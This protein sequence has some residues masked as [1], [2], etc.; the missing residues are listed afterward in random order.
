MTDQNK[1][2]LSLLI[3]EKARELGFAGCGI[4]KAEML[5]EEEDHL[6]KWLSNGYQ[7]NLKYMENHVDKRL[8]PGKLF[9]HAASVISVIINYRPVELIPTEDNYKIARYAYGKD[10]HKVIKNKLKTLIREIESKAGRIQA[11]ILIDSAPILEKAWTRR[12]GLGWVGKNSIVIN[13]EIGSFFFPS[14]IV[15]DLELEYN[16]Q[17][18]ADRCGNC[19][20]CIDS[21]PTGAL[22]APGTLD[23][24]KCISY[25][26][27]E[28]DDP[29]PEELKGRFHDRIFGCDICQ[30]VCPWNAKRIVQTEPSFR[31]SDDLKKMRKQD[32]ENLSREDFDRIFAGMAIRRSKFEGLKRNIALV[33]GK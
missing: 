4:C 32:W 30:E 25:Y 12:A 11:R 9:A 20:R 3:K 7:G 1:H 17:S 23:A 18:M 33:S 19:T 24:R 14:E 28:V 21:C 29:V 5:A 31:L 13:P 6:K 10:H 8:D 2:E 16:E 26:T 15:T 27:I 22:V